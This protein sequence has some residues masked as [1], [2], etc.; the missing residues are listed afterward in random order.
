[1]S[2]AAPW[3]LFALAALPV[4]ALWYRER[5]RSRVREE[6]AF[7]TA[8]LAASV[9]PDRP[10]WRRHAPLLAF[11]LAL[12]VLVV[13]LADPRASHAEVV[14]AR[15][16]MLAG[17]VSGSMASTDVSPTRLQAV[18]RPPRRASSPRCLRAS[19]SG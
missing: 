10:G 13:A 7:V 3:A 8:P 18:Q 12:A 11:A 19:A 6:A 5:E 17:D 1:M 9:V 15:P 16:I 4:F 14:S 2:F